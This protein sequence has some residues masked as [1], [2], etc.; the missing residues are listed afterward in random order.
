MGD[1]TVRD[2]I[3]ALELGAMLILSLVVYLHM[4][5]V[6]RRP[7]RRAWKRAAVVL[8]RELPAEAGLDADVLHA[9]QVDRGSH[10]CHV[11]GRPAHH[12]VHW[13]V[14]GEG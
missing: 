1:W 3:E 8:G 2:T 10:T 12:D 9:A 14:P 5:R 11:C 13:R 4:R 7:S 6:H